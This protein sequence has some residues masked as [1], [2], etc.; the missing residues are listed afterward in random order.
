MEQRFVI[1][2]LAGIL[3][4]GCV[5][6]EQP[7][8]V[9]EEGLV[10]V[11]VKLDFQVAPVDNGTP[12]TKDTQIQDPDF[13]GTVT[14][15]SQIANV[16]ILQFDGVDEDAKLLGRQLYIDHYPLNS[17]ESLSLVAADHPTT[18]VVVCNTFG[19]V[20]VTA[21]CRLSR[22][23]E[24]NY[25]TINSLDEVRTVKNNNEY[26]RL[27]ASAVLPT[28]TS[29]TSAP[30]TL[31]RNVAKVVVE[32]TNSS[33]D[34]DGDDVVN[35]QQVQMTGLNGRHYY[36]AH[37]DDDL[38]PLAFS[39]P[40]DASNPLRFD[41]AQREF[42]AANNPEGASQGR[43]V[44]YTFYIPLNLR[45]TTTNTLQYNKIAGAP[46]GATRF[47]VYATDGSGQPI[48][49]VYYLGAN[50]TNDF[51]LRPNYKYTYTID[52]GSRGDAFYDY[53]IDDL[54]EKIF[55]QDANCYMIHPPMMTGNSRIFSFPVRRAAVFWNA[56]GTNLGVYGASIFPDNPSM[57]SSYVLD[58]QTNWQAEILWSDF[59]MSAYMDGPNKFLHVDSGR[60]FV[61]G[62]HSQPYIK[63]KVPSGM[64]GNV[65]VGLRVRGVIL[66]SWHLWI[67][68]YDPDHY[69]E[70]VSGKYIYPVKGGEKHR[71]N[72]T[73]WTRDT[74]VSVIGYAKGFAMDRN[75]GEL[76]P[77]P[78]HIGHYGL[79]Y[80]YGR[81]DPFPSSTADYATGDNTNGKFYLG[82]T[83]LETV[84]VPERSIPYNTTGVPE[85]K[86]VRYSVS[87]PMVHLYNA[88]GYRGWTSN[89]DDLSGN[90]VDNSALWNDR[91]YW[92]HPQSTGHLLERRKSIYDPC[93]AGWKVPAA[94]SVTTNN[95]YQD[96]GRY[97][98]PEGIENAASTGRIYFRHGSYW[99][100]TQQT[101]YIDGGYKVILTDNQNYRTYES[102]HYKLWVRCVR[103]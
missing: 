12:V 34:Q 39:D 58:G 5:K 51:N 9:D 68:D 48:I 19:E 1:A 91:K 7:Q 13:T 90:G 65:L 22:F 63:V 38:A 60:G 17:G 67:T 31:R 18:L 15:A 75:L 69:A 52:I 61:P 47:C 6:S 36:L 95:A 21:N 20:P 11:P 72:A 57:Y 96:F 14:A 54:S 25:S 26:F 59:D 89:S 94:M 10:R 55:L 87:H 16:A 46:D 102:N 24:N 83:T 2:V 64:K 49:Y 33:Y 8:T 40:Y 97:Y 81:K 82:G 27:S 43:G 80:Q 44:T 99:L 37:V 71:Y 4:A 86:N 53:R 45:G 92:N 101:Y 3:L 50:L 62:T 103:E 74:T 32:I 85:G 41:D 73:E 88:D 77:G 28:V 79:T 66:W 30:I 35:I 23:L 56:P 76:F 29:S 98:Y 84:S 70:I 93:P 78:N 42:P 100:D